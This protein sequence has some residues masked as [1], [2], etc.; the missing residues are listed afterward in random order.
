MA[1]AA[2]AAAKL[3]GRMLAIFGRVQRDCHGEGLPPGEGSPLKLAPQA[4]ACPVEIGA[5]AAASG[6]SS[7][8]A[9]PGD[10]S[11]LDRGHVHEPAVVPL[12]RHSDRGGRAIAV[13]GHYQ[14]SL[15]SPR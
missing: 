9:W 7:R 5:S 6:R 1:A 2:A 14:V 4:S 3:I 13:L 10:A 11:L 8:R 12:E 15:A